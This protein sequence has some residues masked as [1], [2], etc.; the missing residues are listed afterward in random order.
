VKGEISE[1][2]RCECKIKKNG[3]G[4]KSDRNKKAKEE[5]TKDKWRI[6]TAKKDVYVEIEMDKSC[7]PDGRL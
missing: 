1:T 5:G 2:S 3:G 4:G 6:Q 7:S